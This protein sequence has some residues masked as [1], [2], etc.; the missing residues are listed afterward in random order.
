MFIGTADELMMAQTYRMKTAVA[1]FHRNLPCALR[2][3]KIQHEN[4]SSRF[5]KKERAHATHDCHPIV[6]NG[7]E[8]EKK[9][10]G[11]KK[12]SVDYGCVGEHTGLTYRT[13]LSAS[14]MNTVIGH[15]ECDI[16]PH[17]QVLFLCDLH[18]TLHIIFVFHGGGKRR[19]IDNAER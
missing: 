11:G 4:G 17:H 9:L 10:V 3:T 5:H 8:Q 13:E 6:I 7:N 14:R 19:G 2:G 16:L 18:R 1:V 12:D 15:P